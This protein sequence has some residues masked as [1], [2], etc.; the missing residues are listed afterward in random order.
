MKKAVRAKKLVTGIGS[1]ALSLK[2]VRTYFEGLTGLAEAEV[3]R[4]LSNKVVAFIGGKITEAQ[5]TNALKKWMKPESER[6][7]E[8]A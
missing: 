1:T 2:E 8:V 5:M 6:A 7:K 3:V 4:D